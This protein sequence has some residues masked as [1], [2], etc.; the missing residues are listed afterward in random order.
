[1]SIKVILKEIQALISLVS[2]KKKEKIDNNNNKKYRQKT[3]I[4]RYK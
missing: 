3:D 2:I 4:D 1:M